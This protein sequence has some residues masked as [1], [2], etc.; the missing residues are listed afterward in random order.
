MRRLILLRHTKSDWPA[1]LRD[2]DR[3]LAARGRRAAPLMG[4]V[5]VERGL[6]PDRALVSTARRTT[7]TWDLARA[8]HPDLPA[9][10]GEP[11]IYEAPAFQLANVIREVPDPVQTL[12]MVGHNPGMEDLAFELVGSGDE[13]A[14]ARLG[15]K[16]PTGGLAVIA[17]A[18]DSWRDLARHCGRLDAFVVPRDLDDEAE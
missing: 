9:G 4:R 15:R 7:E 12:L 13:A 6:V 2:R 10:T 1:G 18:I 11:R 5:L 3:P 14:R 17:C 16:Y 8:G